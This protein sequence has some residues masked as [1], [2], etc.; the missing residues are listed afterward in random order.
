MT[1]FA[2]LALALVL[3]VACSPWEPELEQGYAVQPITITPNPLAVAVE[4]TIDLVPDWAERQPRD[5]YHLARHTDIDMEP[6]WIAS[7]ADRALDREHGRSRIW[8]VDYESRGWTITD[9]AT[10]IA[11]AAALGCTPSNSGGGTGVT[12]SVCVR[13]RVWRARAGLGLVTFEGSG[14]GRWRVAECR[15]TW[16]SMTLVS[17]LG[18]DRTELP[19]LAVLTDTLAVR[20]PN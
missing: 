19:A 4:D 15:D 10:A 6:C 5:G 1:R 16:A 8:C 3:V 12:V 20:C 14:N 18:E 13:V 7:A 2:P 11:I 17:V 9:E